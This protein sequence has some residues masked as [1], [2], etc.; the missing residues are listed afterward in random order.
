[1]PQ[2]IL[3]LD[4]GRASVKGVILETTLRSAEVV[5]FGLEPVLPGSGDGKGELREAQVEAIGKLLDR[6][7]PFDHVVTNLL[8]NRQACS[9]LEVPFSEPAKIEQTLPFQ[10]EDMTP[11]PI[12]ELFFDYQF[13]RREGKKGSELLVASA[14]KEEIRSHLEFLEES[15]LDPKILL[16]EGVSYAALFPEVFPFPEVEEDIWAVLDIGEEQ[17][18]F[19]AL[20]RSGNSA[21][22]SI[23]IRYFQRGTKHLRRAIVK[24]FRCSDEDAYHYL[25]NYLELTPGQESRVD[26]ELLRAVKGGLTPFLSELLRTVGALEK[27]LGRRPQKLFLVGGGALIPGL[28]AFLSARLNLEVS[29]PDRLPES[30]LSEELGEPP[31]PPIYFKALSLAVRA[32]LKSPFLRINFRRGEFSFKGDL[33]FLKERLRPIFAGLF[34]LLLLFILST[35]T[36]YY[37]LSVENSRLRSAIENKCR[38]ITGKGGLSPN[39][40]LG[41]IRLAIFRAK[42]KVGSSL[43][44]ELSARDVFFEIYDR[45]AKLSRRHK[46]KIVL[47]SWRISPD[48]ID[49]EGET[50]SYAAV[51]YIEGEFK[52]FRCFKDVQKGKIQQRGQNRIVFSIRAKIDCSSS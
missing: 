50:T 46:I 10:L 45:M 48:R 44:P 42:G 38:Q 33:E 7:G 49:V 32:T 37:T 26:Q 51:Q 47:S 5:E 14:P 35:I 29:V 28:S 19:S 2:R 6:L 39:R 11:F 16:P 34:V 3:G 12:E 17:T 52:S 15:Q 21:A 36:Q 13:I 43:I 24:K 40:C 20:G 4:I 8:S 25:Y 41:I 27:R 22:S 18:V 30:I 1:M 31:T 23:Q 9:V